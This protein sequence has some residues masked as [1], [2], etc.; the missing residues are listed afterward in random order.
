MIGPP[1]RL[2]PLPRLPATAKVPP[3]GPVYETRRQHLCPLGGILPP[4]ERGRGRGGL[5]L[6]LVP[7]PK[8]MA[9]SSSRSA[10]RLPVD[11]RVD[12]PPKRVG[13]PADTRTSR[14]NG[15]TNVAPIFRVRYAPA[16]TGRRRNGLMRLTS[17][18]IQGSF[19][20]FVCA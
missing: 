9:E 15:C 18:R 12:R 3:V 1:L 5:M 7:Q 19:Q 10:S 11:R 6:W 20:Y 8:G 17:P 13:S 16:I 4:G 2:S 14:T